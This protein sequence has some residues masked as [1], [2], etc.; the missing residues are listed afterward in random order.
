MLEKIRARL[1]G[2]TRN[3]NSI[4]A[5]AYTQ[6]LWITLEKVDLFIVG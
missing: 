1:K 3:Q 6:I 2:L 5:Q 4:Y